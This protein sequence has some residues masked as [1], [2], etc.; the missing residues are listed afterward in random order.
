MQSWVSCKSF[1]PYDVEFGL[2]YC[3]EIW[4]SIHR[5]VRWLWWG[6]MLWFEL[7]LEWW[8]RVMP[9]QHVE[10][11]SAKDRILG[12]DTLG[13]HVLPR[14]QYGTA[15][16]LIREALV[17]CLVGCAVLVWWYLQGHKVEEGPEDIVWYPTSW[18]LSNCERGLRV[19]CYIQ[20]GETYGK[21]RHTI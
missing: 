18:N 2:C 1:H 17:S 19:L 9:S 21:T 10:L 12:V 7:W 13:Q 16:W 5:D 15:C 4:S 20:H 8:R 14:V 3:Y 6:S 11:E